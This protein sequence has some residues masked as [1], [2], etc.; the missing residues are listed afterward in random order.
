M[1]VLP[2]GYWHWVHTAGQERLGHALPN[3]SHCFCISTYVYPLTYEKQPEYEW[4]DACGNCEGAMSRVY[5][6]C[7]FKQRRQMVQELCVTHSGDDMM[8]NEL[9]NFIKA[10]KQHTA[11]CT[12]GTSEFMREL[13]K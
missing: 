11:K 13:D 2:P 8:D 3:Y 4:N 7:S 12:R 6:A 10:Y 5:N 1:L 9:L